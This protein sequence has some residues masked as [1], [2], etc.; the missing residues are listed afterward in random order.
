MLIKVINVESSLNIFHVPF[1]LVLAF[2]QKEPFLCP[3]RTLHHTPPPEKI[4]GPF[5]PIFLLFRGSFTLLYTVG[6]KTS[7]QT[8]IHFYLKSFKFNT[9][10]TY[11]YHQ[12]Y[13]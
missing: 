13:I 1:A 7:T 12:V 3:L 10:I 4:L 2:A 9:N 8:G 5:M 6:D 11:L